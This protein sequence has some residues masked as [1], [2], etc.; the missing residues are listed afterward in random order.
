V[1]I[2]IDSM[3]I[4]RMEGEKMIILVMYFKSNTYVSLGAGRA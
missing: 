3:M 1:N 2:D 4:V